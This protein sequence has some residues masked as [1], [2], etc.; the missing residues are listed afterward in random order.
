MNELR[1][2]IF[3]WAGTLVDFGSRAPAAAFVEAFA[4]F[5]ITATEE[6]ARKPMGLPKRAHIEA[7]LAQPRLA[8]LWLETR[9]SAPDEAAIDAVYEVFVPIN[10]SIA[11]REANLIPGALEA[12][13][14][15][16]KHTVKIGSTTGYVRP[17]MEGVVE[18]AAAQGFSPD[19][20]V[21]A[22]EAPVGRPSAMA[23]YHCFVALGVHEPS[24]IVKVDDTA[25]GIAE[26]RAAGT[27]TI[28]LSLSGNAVGLT[29]QALNA[30]SQPEKRQHRER[31]GSIL[32]EAGADYVID[33]IADIQSPLAAIG[34]R[35]AA[36]EKPPIY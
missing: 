3:D 35:I 9:G 4:R 21:C 25:P 1:A 18:R 19:C 23:M 6:E 17:I 16:R 33:S 14:L 30:L 12:A 29:E 5:Q 11:K 8:K 22:D 15:L 20:L 31:A 2:V 27:W 24:R 34:A 36:G 7:M 28:G 26:G 13:S 32:S 10:A